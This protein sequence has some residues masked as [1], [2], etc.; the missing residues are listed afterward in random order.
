[1]WL[2]ICVRSP[3]KLTVVCDDVIKHSLVK[4]KLYVPLSFLQASTIECLPKPRRKQSS[5]M[6]KK[7]GRHGSFTV[8]LWQHIT[9][10]YV[11]YICWAWNLKFPAHKL[12][13]FIPST[14]SQSALETTINCQVISDSSSGLE[15]APHEQEKWHQLH[16]HSHST[17]ILFIMRVT[18][19]LENL[20]WK[21][22]LQTWRTSL[23]LL[24]ELYCHICIL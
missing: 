1:M 24:L 2:S 18:P 15:I 11:I 5:N 14:T 3:I 13:S 22:Q 21:E 4:L 10:S 8:T 16:Q 19:E 7:E 23:V 9:T 17:E 6:G 12:I 20:G